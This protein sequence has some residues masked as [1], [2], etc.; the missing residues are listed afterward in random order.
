MKRIELILKN[1]RAD[2][3]QKYSIGSET[4]IGYKITREDVNQDM[5]ET[6]F[7]KLHHPGI[8]ILVGKRLSDNNESVYIGQSDN[9]AKR[10]YQHKGGKD[11][12]KIKGKLFWN[13]C[14]AFV[15][16]DNQMQ[17][18]HAEY[19][20]AAFCKLV[21][22]AN[23]YILENENKPS[24][25]NISEGDQIFC[26]DFT[27]D[28][29]LL[30]QLMGF[31]IF[32]SREEEKDDIISSSNKQ[33]IDNS[34]RKGYEDVKYVCATGYSCETADANRGFVVLENSII[35]KEVSKKAS[36]TIKKLRRDLTKRGYIKEENGKLVFK[37]EFLFESGGIAASFV[38]GRTASSKEWKEK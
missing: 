37:R 15:T 3:S 11:G 38:L 12:E 4:T 9:V 18:G 24:D 10:L 25:R 17:K 33:I 32:V 31:P 14:M 5:E 8:Y 1:G 26:D 7:E 2:G 6:F 13:E 23:R 35:S 20:E 27:E 34:A 36:P 19:L 21:Y 16:S 22:E 29:D 28:C 30:S